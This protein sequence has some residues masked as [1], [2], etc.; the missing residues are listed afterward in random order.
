MNSSDYRVEPDSELG[1]ALK[2]GHRVILNCNDKD[3]ADM[4]ALALMLQAGT[5]TLRRTNGNQRS[6]AAERPRMI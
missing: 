2:D 1:W 4:L 3:D 6:R 5:R